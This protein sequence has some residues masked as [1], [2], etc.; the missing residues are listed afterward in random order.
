MNAILNSIIVQIKQAI[1][2]PMFRFCVLI[3]PIISGFLLGMIYKNKSVEDFMIYAFIGAGIGVFWGSI[4]FSSASDIDREKWMGTLP[5]IFVSPVGFENIIIG[6]ILGNTIWGIFSVF[7]NMVTVYIFFDIPIK[8]S[9]FNFFVLIFILMILS[10]IALGFM[11]CGLFTLS[12]KVRLFMNLIE[13]PIIILTGMVFPISIFPN[14]I[15]IISHI[16]S[17]TWAMKGFRLAVLGGTKEE[18]IFVALGLLVVTI[19]YFS[20]SILSF[21][22]IT[23]KCVINGTLEVF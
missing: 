20:I 22:K 6:K 2:R 10:M 4:C 19:I 21:R 16:L 5:V 1:T 18:M 8:F 14:F 11:L 12:R 13:Y 15:Q 7:L 9:N 23:E 3:N 17:P